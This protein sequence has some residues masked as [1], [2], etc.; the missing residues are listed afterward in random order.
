[1]IM[2]EMGGEGGVEGQD[3]PLPTH[4]SVAIPWQHY[5]FAEFS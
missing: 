1:M 2:E 4:L 3:V 5:S